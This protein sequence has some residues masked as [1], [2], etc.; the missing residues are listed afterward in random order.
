MEELTLEDF[1]PHVGAKF[2]V[3]AAGVDVEFELRDAVPSPHPGPEGRRHP[4]S[5]VFLGP[6]ASVLPQ[7]IYTVQHPERGPL[8]LF[9]V[10][11]GADADGVSY[12]AVFN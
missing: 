8:D 1:A 11:I 6:P 9:L 2:R 12:E 5:L 7:Q 10:A 4:F 3:G